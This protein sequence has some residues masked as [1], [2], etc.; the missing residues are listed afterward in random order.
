VAAAQLKGV[1]MKPLKSI[2]EASPLLIALIVAI[3]MGTYLY[4]NGGNLLSSAL[5]GSAV[6]VCSTSFSYY[7]IYR[8]YMKLRRGAPFRV[9]DKVQ[10]TSGEY[11]GLKGTVTKTRYDA[12][13]IPTI[14]VV[15]NA[16][17]STD[18]PHIFF[19]ENLCRSK[20]NS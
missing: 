4:L 20:E 8:G 11:I 19:E 5:A 6:G 14:F 7:F 15:I 17:P 9:G 16:D 10:I 13:A 2:V 3:T 1:M 18:A 12:G